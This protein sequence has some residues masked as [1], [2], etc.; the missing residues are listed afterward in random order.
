MICIKKF[1]DLIV[2]RSNSRSSEIFY[3]AAS[4]RNARRECL[5]AAQAR[6]WRREN[7]AAKMIRDLVR[8][9]EMT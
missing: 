1:Y 8:N 5:V 4:M 9:E 7:A 3:A 6:D 2:S